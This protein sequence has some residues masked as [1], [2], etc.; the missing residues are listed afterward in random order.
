M[1]RPTRERKPTETLY[2]EGMSREIFNAVVKCLH[3]DHHPP[4]EA[5]RAEGMRLFN[6][7]RHSRKG[8]GAAP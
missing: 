5:E 7:W 8:K 2:K 3:L 1:T 4:T 6:A